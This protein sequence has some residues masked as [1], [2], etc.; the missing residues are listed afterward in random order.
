MNNRLVT[1]ELSIPVE[2]NQRFSTLT[3]KECDKGRIIGGDLGD[4]RFWGFTTQKDR[5]VLVN[6]ESLRDDFEGWTNDEINNLA[7]SILD[8]SYAS[9]GAE[10]I[11]HS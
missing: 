10:C 6:P 8:A 4:L 1:T 2:A 11:E 5:T 9:I 7:Q 3:R